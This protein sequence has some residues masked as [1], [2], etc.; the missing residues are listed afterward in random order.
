VFGWPRERAEDENF[1]KR[2]GALFQ[3]SRRAAF[4]IPSPRPAPLP[5][6]SNIPPA[7]TP[8]TRPCNQ[9]LQRVSRRHWKCRCSWGHGW[10]GRRR[11]AAGR[12]RRKTK[13][14]ST[15]HEH[16][17]RHLYRFHKI[18]RDRDTKDRILHAVA[19]NSAGRKA[20]KENYAQVKK[21]S[22]ECEYARG[23]PTAAVEP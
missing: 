21:K 15:P 11:R 7:V 22:S 6:S 18:S 12:R 20:A 17:K 2:V 9:P 16:N 23:N 19:G 4:R 13:P 3:V 10:R 14:L 8:A 1:E 5:T